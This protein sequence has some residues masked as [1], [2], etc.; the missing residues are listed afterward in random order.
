MN[1]SDLVAKLADRFEL[2]TV[3]DA[4]AAVAT[5]LQGMSEALAQGRRVEIR[6]FGSFVLSQ[7]PPRMGRNP[8]SGEP[9]QIPEKRMPHFKS[10]KALRQGM[11]ASFDGRNSVQGQP[12]Q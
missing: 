12:A 2:L 10:G 5:I 9:V 11:E 3:Q 1:R 7:R 4:E 6:R 8:R